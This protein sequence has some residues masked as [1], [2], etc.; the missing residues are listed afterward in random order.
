MVDERCSLGTTPMKTRIIYKEKS[1]LLYDSSPEISER[2][3]NRRGEFNKRN[4]SLSWREKSLS[5]FATALCKSGDTCRITAL[6][7]V[8][9]KI[10]FLLN[11]G[12][13]LLKYLFLSYILYPMLIR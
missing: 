3:K 6:F 13:T 7:H 4:F 8:Y 12:S 5:V 1:G 9:K 11:L 2:V 10:L